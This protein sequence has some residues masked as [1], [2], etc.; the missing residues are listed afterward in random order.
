MITEDRLVS[1]LQWLPQR[2]LR[3]PLKHGGMDIRSRKINQYDRLVSAEIRLE[4]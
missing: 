1:M 3:Q 2:R 4:M